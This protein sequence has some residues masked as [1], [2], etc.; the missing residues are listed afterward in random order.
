MNFAELETWIEDQVGAANLLQISTPVLK[1]SPINTTIYQTYQL[2]VLIKHEID[3]TC[4]EELGLMLK[5]HVDNSDYIPLPNASH[6]KLKPVATPS[7]PWDTQVIDYIIA[8]GV[9]LS[10]IWVPEILAVLIPNKA[11]KVRFYVISNG[12]AIQSANE[13]IVYELSGSLYYKT[14]VIP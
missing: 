4:G 11:S 7:T 13:Y 14:V 12:D 8:Q 2:V 1:E 5:V 10:Q 9:L 6:I 3:D